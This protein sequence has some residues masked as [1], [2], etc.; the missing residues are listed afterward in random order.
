MPIVF[1]NEWAVAW[2]AALNASPAY[3]TAAAT[4]EGTI[5]AAVVPSVGAGPIAAAF[6]DVWHGECRTARAA[7]PADLAGAD[8][9]IEGA[10]DAWRELLSGRLA[11]LMALLSGRIQLTRGELARLLPYAGAARELV[12]LAASINAEFPPDWGS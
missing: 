10:P 1:S 11:P 12:A 2:G 4:W 6:L 3:Q 7:T 5:A 9:V 8:F